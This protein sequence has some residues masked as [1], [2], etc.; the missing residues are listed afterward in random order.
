LRITG[1]WLFYWENSVLLFSRVLDMVIKFFSEIIDD[2]NITFF[3]D[4]VERSFKTSP[5]GE[6]LFY[7]MGG[8]W[9][10]PYV[11][12][13]A[14]T[15]ARLFK[16]QLWMLRVFYGSIILGSFIL[17]EALPD[18]IESSLGFILVN[19]SFLI[20]FLFVNWLVFRNDLSVLNRLTAPL[21]FSVYY[22]EHAKNLGAFQLFLGFLVCL[23]LS[24]WGALIYTKI[25]Q[26]IG[27][28]LFSAFGFTAINLAYMYGLKF[29]PSRR[30]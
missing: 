21:P 18:I 30:D 3:S 20:L 29:T 9:S 22:R 24:L 26:L 25:N 6:R 14:E 8:F 28:V 12:P 2:M 11:V 10:K 19:S 7:N 17:S 15:E 23:G 1:W 16:K 13:D 5:D 4:T 27:W